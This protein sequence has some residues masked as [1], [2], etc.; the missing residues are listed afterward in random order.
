[1]PHLL[2]NFENETNDM[3]HKPPAGRNVGK[4]A[5]H[6]W[7]RTRTGPVKR[8]SDFELY[9]ASEI[10]IIGGGRIAKGKKTGGTKISCWLPD[11]QR[12]IVILLTFGLKFLYNRLLFYP[13]LYIY[14]YT[15]PGVTAW[16]AGAS[17]TSQGVFFFLVHLFYFVGC[18]SPAS[19]RAFSQIVVSGPGKQL[20]PPA[21]RSYVVL[22]AGQ[23]PATLSCE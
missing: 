18:V 20:T 23:A 12:D 2:I 4:R 21:T 11:G 10:A 22:T 15:I 14:M 19:S 9:Y 7:E 16:C 5:G 13:L 1:M 3:K 17:R 8:A 6:T